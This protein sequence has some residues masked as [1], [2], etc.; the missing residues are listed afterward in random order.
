M[1]EKAAIYVGKRSV[2]SC[3]RVNNHLYFLLY[4]LYSR[5][6]SPCTVPIFDP[7]I[8]LTSSLENMNLV[9]PFPF[10]CS[11]NSPPKS[12]FSL[13]SS[14]FKYPLKSM[15][16]MPIYCKLT[17][18]TLENLIGTNDP[19]SLILAANFIFVYCRSL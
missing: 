7:R 2:K 17:P 8:R 6:I 10:F 4:I 15:S 16:T 13:V 19:I 11:F 18:L 14:F 5:F 1:R 9:F 3:D 12:S